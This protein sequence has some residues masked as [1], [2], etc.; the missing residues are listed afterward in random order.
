[1]T[2]R[3][4]NI[5]KTKKIGSSIQRYTMFER[6]LF[7]EDFQVPPVCLSGKKQRVG[8]HE[9]GKIGGMVLTGEN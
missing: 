1:M 7:C 4:I 5:F 3:I 2:K 8:E 9:Y 6:V